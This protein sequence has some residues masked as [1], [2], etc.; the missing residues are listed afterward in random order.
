MSWESWSAS[1][2]GACCL[3]EPPR[4]AEHSR[5][6]TEQKEGERSRRKARER[7]ATVRAH[8]QAQ[9][10]CNY[11]KPLIIARG[12]LAACISCLSRTK[13]R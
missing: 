2:G 8:S 10:A 7:V 9:E 13:Q 3:F 4:A 1:A 6:Y 11:L 12:G 5:Q